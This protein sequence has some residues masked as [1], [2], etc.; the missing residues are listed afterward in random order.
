MVDC[1][2]VEKEELSNGLLTRLS[3]NMMNIKQYPIIIMFRLIVRKPIRHC[4]CVFFDFMFLLVNLPKV[5]RK[6]ATK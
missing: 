6:Y 2:W 3:H 4:V 1:V 5:L